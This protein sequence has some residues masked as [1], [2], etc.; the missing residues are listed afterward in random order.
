MHIN[1]DEVANP[2]NTQKTLNEKLYNNSQRFANL[3]NYCSEKK[4]KINE[5]ER[6][7][8]EERIFNTHQE[9]SKSDFEKMLE[10]GLLIPDNP[11]FERL[12]SLDIPAS[13]KIALYS[14]YKTIAGMANIE[15]LSLEVNDR[16][17]IIL[18]AY[19]QKIK[20]NIKQK[21]LDGFID[22]TGTEI[23]LGSVEELLDIGLLINMLKNEHNTR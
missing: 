2:N 22:A 16:E 14:A 9:S 11:I 8:V 7:V 1:A 12:E 23:P 3:E 15:N 5:E 10:E 17:H 13:D 21:H 19:D 4:L 6:S 20:L 18:K